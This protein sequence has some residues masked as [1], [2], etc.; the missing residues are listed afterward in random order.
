MVGGRNTVIS[1]AIGTD[2]QGF[3]TLHRKASLSI[4]QC[5]NN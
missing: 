5:C 4:E 3:K 2:N 1:A